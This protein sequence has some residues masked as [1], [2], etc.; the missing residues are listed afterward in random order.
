MSRVAGSCTLLWAL[1][2]H[3]AAGPPGV[4]QAFEGFRSPPDDARVMMRWWWF[5]PAVSHD[6]LQREI[7]A[8]KAGGFG[9]VEIQP[10]YP[11][12][13]DDPHAG[14]RNLRY[15][16][17]EFIAA[18]RFAAEQARA[19]NLRVDLTL[20]SGWPFGGPHVRADTASAMVRMIEM[21][22]TAGDLT[23]PVPRVGAGERLLCAFVVAGSGSSIDVARPIALTLPTTA[24]IT[25]P[26]AAVGSKGDRTVLFFLQS[27]TGQQVK[28]A[29]IGG[30]G[31]VIDHLNRAAVEE[32][33]SVVG[34][35][36]LSAFPNRRPDTVFSDS[37]EVYEA[38]WTGDF[39]QEFSRRRGYDVLPHLPALFFDN[40]PNV[41]S[42]RHDW[43]RTLS[44]LT[45][46]R[47]LTTVNDW[48]SSRGTRFRS[49]TYGYPPVTLSSNQRVALPEGEGNQWRAFSTTRWAA[50][51]AYLYDQ[52]VVSVEA[53]T[54]LHSPA[55]RATPLDMKAEADVLFLQGANQLIGHGWPYSPPS[56]LA[57]G[58]SFYAAA[59][60]SDQN[61]WWLVMPDIALYLQ[62]L[63]ALLR[64]GE[65]AADVA[66]LMPTH[67]AWAATRHGHA[68]VSVEAPNYVS[69][70][71]MAA[72]LDTGFG[73]AYIDD[74]AIDK[75]SRYRALVLPRIKR[76]DVDTYRQI[77]AYARQGGIVVS[78]GEP[79]SVEAG[80]KDAEIQRRAV[81]AISESLFT[82]DAART[83]QLS[84]DSELGDALRGLLEPDMQLAQR[85]PEIGFVHR[86]LS[87]ADIY[88]IANTGPRE[89]KVQAKF[90]DS[91]RRPGQWWYPVTGAKQA[92]LASGTELYN[93]ELA[94][95]ESRVLV[96]A[97]PDETGA[98]S[99]AFGGAGEMIADLSRNWSVRFDSLEPTRRISVPQSWTDDEA[100][101]YFSGTA[102]Y[103]RKF[104]LPKRWMR[105]EHRI[106]LHFGTGTAVPSRPLVRGGRAW[107]ESPV[108]EAAVVFV[109]GK[110]AGSIWAPPYYLDITD[111][112]RAGSNDVEVRVA[113]LA[114]NAL[115]GRA[116]VDYRLLNARYGER[117]TPQDMKDLQPVPAGLLGPVTLRAMT[118]R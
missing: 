26:A 33:L 38:D 91:A 74:A 108:R 71:I 30:E 57:P 104:A 20:G 60:F 113:N 50:S 63:S 2:S 41:A 105:P 53:W 93:I 13:L 25:V 19:Q 39:E 64:Q 112:L 6:E 51:A 68:T 23:V 4:A 95:Y 3:A 94:P 103:Q 115:A 102:L 35:R 22:V 7:L 27:R 77:Q 17:D 14:I 67:D 109:N 1:F 106:V 118:Q 42:I 21:P 43:G 76:M 9:G 75:L 24:R 99:T 37:L 97:G 28:R 90:R 114:L 31:L 70:G 72:L 54:W 89:V 48:A 44:E 84:N 78:V 15:L 73:V 40:S 61:P 65:P 10:V 52:P 29:G 45:D 11:L 16:S 55:F 46:E 85:T 83:R 32:H 34:E 96:F 86:R 12:S 98:Q 36:L 87:D 69:Q 116:P 92:A 111:Q 5:G 80:Y 81:R 56:A 18:L 107:L 66:I 110:R 88:F 117:F 59:V 8:M 101:R 100:T 79:P 58:W 82:Q 47:Y 62:R 49:Q